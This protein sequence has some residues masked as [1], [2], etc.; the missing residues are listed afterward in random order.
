[1]AFTAASALVNRLSP[2]IFDRH[3]RLSRYFAFRRHRK[4]DKDER[5]KERRA[6]P[7]EHPAT[8]GRDRRAVACARLLAHPSPPSAA[9]GT[10][11]GS[12]AAISGEGTGALSAG[13]IPH[14]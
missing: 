9:S 6:S 3:R 8:A 11:L 5:Y 1:M 7:R 2:D 13:K 10:T 14:A 12:V 4:G